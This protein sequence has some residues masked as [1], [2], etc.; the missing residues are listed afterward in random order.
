MDLSAGLPLCFFVRNT[1]TH[2][3]SSRLDVLCIR[4]RC[5][6]YM[7]LALAHIR[8]RGR[9]PEVFVNV[10]SDCIGVSS[11]CPCMFAHGTIQTL[12]T[13]HT[14]S[15]LTVADLRTVRPVGWAK[16]SIMP[17]V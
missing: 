3:R 12:Q 13:L 2:S 15:K 7:L 11:N 5:F 1:T 14:E 4:L 9:G 10:L 8:K 17:L 16:P 6:K